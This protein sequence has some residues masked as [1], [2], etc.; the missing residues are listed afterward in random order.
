MTWPFILGTSGLSW[1]II[2]Y[3]HLAFEPAVN[4]IH[5][6]RKKKFFEEIK[7]DFTSRKEQLSLA[8]H[9]LISQFGFFPLNIPVSRGII[10]SLIVFL[11][12]NNII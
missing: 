4:R 2:T 3:T 7:I 10:S 1:G 6:F 8:L 9:S 11:V 12:C 5:F